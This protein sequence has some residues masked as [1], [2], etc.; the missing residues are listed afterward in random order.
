M[1]FLHEKALRTYN[2]NYLFYRSFFMSNLPQ[3]MAISA[4]VTPEFA[5]ILTP[6][7]SGFGRQT[8]PRF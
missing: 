6:E 4:E 2:H 8:S 5:T 7:A 1:L 3:G